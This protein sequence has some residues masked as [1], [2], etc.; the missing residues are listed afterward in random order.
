MIYTFYLVQDGKIRLSFLDTEF[1]LSS[2]KTYWM[3][4]VHDVNGGSI[5]DL[6]LSHDEIFLISTGMDGNI[7]VFKLV[8][9]DEIDNYIQQE[10]ATLP[11]NGKVT[12]PNLLLTQKS[13]Y[14]TPLLVY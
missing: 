2:A 8:P 4:G 9:A 10:K 14:I 1:D 6:K 13:L 5:T 3:V 12:F 7:F 11:K